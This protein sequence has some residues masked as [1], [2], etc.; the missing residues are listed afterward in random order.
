VALLYLTLHDSN[1]A[2]KGIDWDVL[3]RLYEKG[4]IDDLKNKN[5]SVVFTNEGLA[6]AEELF[7]SHF[8]RR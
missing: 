7:K 1:R 6:Q 5:K 3:D 4:L 2:W 8:A